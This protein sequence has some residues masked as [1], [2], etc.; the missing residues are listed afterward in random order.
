MRV[1]PLNHAPKYV[2]HH[3]KTPNLIE[4][5]RSSTRNN[6]RSSTT[7][8]LI[9]ATAVLDMS[10]TFCWGNDMSV[11]SSSLKRFVVV[12]EVQY[13]CWT[14][15]V[16]CSTFTYLNGCPSPVFCTACTTFLYIRKDMVPVSVS[17]D[18]YATT[19]ISEKYVRARSMTKIPPKTG[20]D[21]F[22]SRQ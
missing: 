10:S 13:S 3:N 15:A 2:K 5:T 21:F 9:W 7:A 11:S 18:R 6:L 12:I 22:G 20:P 8:A 17:N 16:T 19:L 14:R 4:S 1:I